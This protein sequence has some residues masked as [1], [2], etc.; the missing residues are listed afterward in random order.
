MMEEEKS[1]RVSNVFYYILRGRRLI[2]LCAVLGLII[3]IIFSGV[4]YLRGQISKEYQITS[5]VAIVVQSE[6][7][8]NSIVK[9]SPDP[10][11]VRLAQELTD[12]AIIIIKSKATMEA[13][14]EKAN[15]SGIT[16]SDI[17]NNLTVIKDGD[18][19]ILELSL[20]WRSGV[21]GVSIMEAINEASDE[22]LHKT[23]KIGNVSVLTPPSSKYIIGGSVSASTWVLFAAIGAFLA[24]AICVLKLFIAPL[25]TNVKDLDEFNSIKVLGSIPYD[26]RF[27]DSV[28]FASD[29]SKAKKAISSLANVLASRMDMEG[30][31]KVIIT[32]SIHSE[33]RT[34]LTANIAQQLAESGKKTLMID[35]DF[36]NPM[37]SSMFGG[38]IP[39]EKTLNA[40]YFG[41]A[42][43]TD[44]VCH[45]AGCLDLLPVTL[46]DKEIT[47]NDAMLSIIGSIAD[48]YDYA[49]FD[50]API[51]DDA[52]VI[53]LR[54]IT[55]TSLFV[56][57]F[58]Y[59]EFEEI[60]DAIW[61]LTGSGI[62]VNGYVVTYVK[63]FKDILREAQK[64]SGFMFGPRK[65]SGKDKISAKKEKKSGKDKIS[66]KKEKNSKK[67]KKK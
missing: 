32:S 36:K 65:R 62:D 20:T 49:V 8:N 61:H 14:I 46:S 58:D 43:E 1:F 6:S 66:T 54:N 40:V 37:L 38:Q 51:S 28:P 24:A 52:K 41:D 39:Y 21:E 11:D 18:T 12:T 10:E 5:S 55:D 29:G 31:K 26:K 7:V 13:A 53:N 30:F 16:I 23:L 17:Q 9:K 25:L 67:N 50:C 42:D 2:L 22:V 45:I 33:G 19:Q 15:I 59:A 63:T 27:E 44:A 4:K 57:R 48:R 64:L 56:A 47:L 60:K 3:G 34:S 35:C